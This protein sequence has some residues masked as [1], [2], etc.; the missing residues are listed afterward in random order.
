MERLPRVRALR[1]AL[2]VTKLDRIGRSVVNLIE[3][4]DNLRPCPE[5]DPGNGPGGA[6]LDVQHALLVL[7]QIAAEHLE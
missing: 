6:A 4:V 7:L 1:D 3:A 2:V 5:R